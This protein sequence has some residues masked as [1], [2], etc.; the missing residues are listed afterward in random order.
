MANFFNGSPTTDFQGLIAYVKAHTPE[1]MLS[2]IRASSVDPN[3]L[4]SIGDTV[5]MFLNDEGKHHAKVC[6][7]EGIRQLEEEPQ[8]KAPDVNL[9]FARRNFCACC[10]PEEPVEAF[11]VLVDEPEI[12]VAD[13]VLATGIATGLAQ[14]GYPKQAN[15]I[16][17][18]LDQI[19][20]QNL[21]LKFEE[22]G[23]EIG[24]LKA[25][26]DHLRQQLGG[27]KLRDLKW[28][29]NPNVEPVPDGILSMDYDAIRLPAQVLD[30]AR[31]AVIMQV[32]N[33]RK[34]WFVFFYD[35]ED[36]TSIMQRENSE[37]CYVFFY[38]RD[39]NVQVSDVHY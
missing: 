13:P 14:E 18:A 34:M 15:I 6:Y 20:A 30:R 22:G 38:Y 7:G 36:P 33:D 31:S 8:R 3:D 27:R 9:M 2:D 24:I 12:I 32:S 35:R 26:R 17:T 10:F 1:Q 28:F 11:N 39:G 23:I 16:V 21:L 29:W 19:P 37:L 25:L 4:P 5:K